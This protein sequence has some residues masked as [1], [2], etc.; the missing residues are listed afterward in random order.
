MKKILKTYKF[1]LYP[2]KEQEILLNKTFG[3]TRFVF[4]QMLAERQSI[5][6][7][8]KEDKEKLYKFKYKTEKQYKEEY[9][10]LKEVDSVALQQSRVDLD[11]AY[12]N[13]FQ[14]QSGKRKGR[15][16]GFPKFKSKK[17]NRKTFRT[18]N[19]NNNIDIIFENKRI[20]LPKLK[21][22]K[23]SDDRQFNGI[24][25]NVTVEK[26]PTGKYFACILVEEYIQINIHQVNSTSKAIGLDYDSKNLFTSNEN[27]IAGYPR[28]YRKYEKKLAKERRKFSRKK[29]GSSRRNKQRI[30]VARVHEKIVNSRRDF[31]NKLSTQIVKEYDIIG[32]ETL[33]MQAMSQC[34]NLAK[35]TLDNSW[36]YFVNML[37]YK[38]EWY[39]KHLVFADKWYASTKTCSNCGYKNVEL[40]LADREWDCPICHT[41]HNRDVNAG[42]NLMNNAIK[43]T[44]GTTEINAHGDNI[45][46][47]ISIESS[48]H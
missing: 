10:W 24:I 48:C 1:R 32:V 44:V 16:I 42:I 12:K 13:F 15:K 36:G 39:G 4:N 11:M 14:S 40:T 41:H 17:D 27:K 21:W 29:I 30:K 19:V 3:C 2:N 26:T 37:E 38:C 31:H 9:D 7:E 20:K 6:S 5:Y 23:Y 45:N 35:S 46:L 47:L 8:L 25:K 22:I 28:F 33:N 18:I 34:L 43:N